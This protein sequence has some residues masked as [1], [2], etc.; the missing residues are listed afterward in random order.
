MKQ[1]KTIL[2]LCVAISFAFVFSQ[3]KKEKDITVNAHFY[4]LDTAYKA[5]VRLFLDNQD[6][7]VLPKLASMPDCGQA[8]LNNIT[9][10][11]PLK[12][13]KYK[14]EV[15]DT[16][17]NILSSSSFSFSENSSSGSGG[18]GREESSLSGDCMLLG[19]GP[20]D[21]GPK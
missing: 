2:I 16:S 6:R 14:L 18:V 5:P 12:S 4:Y 20:V 17:G 9:L 19:S 10:S 13:G 21:N 7:G 15:K 11:F 8:D 1:F 3:C